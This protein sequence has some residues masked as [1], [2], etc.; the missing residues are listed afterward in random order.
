MRKKTFTVDNL[1]YM[2]LIDSYKNFILF[3]RAANSNDI[4]SISLCTLYVL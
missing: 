3:N 4:K 1:I 2:H